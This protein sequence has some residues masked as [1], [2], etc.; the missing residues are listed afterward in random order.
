MDVPTPFPRLS[1]AE[2]MDRFG[3]DKP[4][5]R[6]GLEIVKD[7]GDVFAQSNPSRCSG[8]RWTTGGVVRAINAKGFAGITTGQIEEL[9]RMAQILRR[10]GPGVHQGRERRMEVAHREVFHRRGKDPR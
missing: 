4:D 6:F 9:T 2:A 8:A 5:T 3:S 1:Y 10:E 7:L